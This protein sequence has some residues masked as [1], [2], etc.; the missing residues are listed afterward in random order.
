MFRVK[1]NSSFEDKGIM[2]TKFKLQLLG[3][4]EKGRGDREI[5]CRM[6]DAWGWCTGKTQ[7]KGMGREEGGGF[8]MGNAGVP[9]ADSFQCL[10]KLIQCCKV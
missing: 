3:E 9:V 5:R 6:L 2:N 4:E 8:G 10:A 1:I 7:R